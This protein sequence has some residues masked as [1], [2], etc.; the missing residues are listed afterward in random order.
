MGERGPIPKRSDQ[1]R[2]RNKTWIDQANGT[3]PPRSGKGATKAA[4]RDYAEGIGLQV[5]KDATRAQIIELVE[6]GGRDDD[7]HPLALEWFDS[8]SQSGQHV[9]YEP[10]DWATARVLAELLSKALRS[11][12]PTA[13]LVERWQAGA[14]ELLTTEGARRRAMLE[15]ERH[16]DAGEEESDDVTR[17]DDARR[18]LRGESG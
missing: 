16:Q 11:R 9:F 17:L 8:L 1:R 14:T 3:T 6:S 7:W 13:A 5:P 15:L 12:R 10:S 4:W 18:R 2:R